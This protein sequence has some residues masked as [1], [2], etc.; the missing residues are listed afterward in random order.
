VN[1]ADAIIDYLINIGVTDVFGLP[2]EII[3]DFLY[4]ADRRKE[5]IASHLAFHEQA[6]SYAACGYAQVSGRLGVAYATHGPGIA[7][8]MTT[9]IDAYRDSIPLIIITAHSKRVS[10]EEMRFFDNQ[11]LNVVETLSKITKE[12]IRI[13]DVDYAL[14]KLIRACHTATSGRKG[15]VVLDYSSH[16]FAKDI[17]VDKA[18]VIEEKRAGQAIMP[19]IIDTIKKEI[20]QSKRPVFLIGDGLRNSDSAAALCRVASSARIP[21]LSSRFS[22]DIIPDSNYYFGSIGSHGTRYGNFILSKADLIVAIGNRMAFSPNSKSF[23]SIVMNNRIIRIDID[24]SEFMRKI[25]NSIDFS[26]DAFDVLRQLSQDMPYYGNSSEWIAICNE[27][28]TTLFEKDLY[29]PVTAISRIISEFDENAPIVSD[30]G[31]NEMWLSRAYAHSKARNRLL[32]SKAFGVLGSAL[33]RAIGAHFGCKGKVVCFTGDQGLQMNIQEFQF[34]ADGRIPILIVIMNNSSSGM[35]RSREKR[36][37]D[38]HFLL[39][40]IESGYSVPDF[41]A[42]ARAYQIDYLRVFE[43]DVNRIPEIISGLMLPCIMDMHIDESIDVTPYLPIGN[44]CQ[45]PEPLL[46]RD[47]FKRLN[48]L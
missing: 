43:D 47:L 26:A 40:T 36:R 42:I 16:L 15:P 35:I 10:Y 44:P 31:N 38:P 19:R 33:P 32:H 27:L 6:A 8:M 7:N 9:I 25:P 3:L 2:G 13:D 29:F 21:V 11:E 5:K 1:I 23:S 45:D 20:G 17:I 24:K 34:I 48:K 22:Q 39:A 14:P 30:V 18:E 46:D 41:S 4:A 37:G 28:K 12:I